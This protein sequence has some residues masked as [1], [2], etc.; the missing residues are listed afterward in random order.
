MTDIVFI[1]GAFKCF[2]HL[3]NPTK[4]TPSRTLQTAGLGFQALIEDMMASFLGHQ[5]ITL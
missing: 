2:E 5:G 3:S 1:F 4:S